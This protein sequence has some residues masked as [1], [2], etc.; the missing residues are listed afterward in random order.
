MKFIFLILTLVLQGCFALSK[1]DGKTSAS[2]SDPNVIRFAQVNAAIIQPYCLSCHTNHP[3]GV[4]FRNY[5][6][7]AMYVLP[8][9]PEFSIIW[10]K[11]SQD[12]MPKNG[13]ALSVE[14]KQLLFNWIEQGAQ[15]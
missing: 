13:P 5:A 15:N 6:E 3:N 2:S 11:V 8:G 10:E 7:V 4:N 1:N 9:R 14:E 12:L